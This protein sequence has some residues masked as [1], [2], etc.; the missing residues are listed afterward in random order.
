MRVT[1]ILAV[2]MC[3]IAGGA[4]AGEKCDP[5]TL[6]LHGIFTHGSVECNKAWL[7]RPASYFA[8]TAARNCQSLPKTEAKQYIMRGMLDFDK[9]VAADG[10]T[11]TCKEIDGMMT[12]L[13]KGDRR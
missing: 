8:L 4:M 11:A 7:E 6:I 3:V 1:M 10:K 12:A 9:R 13:E 5:A 2:T